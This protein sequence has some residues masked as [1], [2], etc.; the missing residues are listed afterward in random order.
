MDPRNYSDD[1]PFYLEK[2]KIEKDFKTVENVKFLI[3]ESS[4]ELKRPLRKDEAQYLVTY[5]RRFDFSQSGFKDLDVLNANI[6]RY[7][8]KVLSPDPSSIEQCYDAPYNASRE[9]LIRQ[10]VSGQYSYKEGGNISGMDVSSGGGSSGITPSYVSIPTSTEVKLTPADI[11]ALSTARGGSTTTIIPTEFY[12]N[13]YLDFDSRYRVPLMDLSQNF[14]FNVNTQGTL[15]GIVKSNAEIVNIRKIEVYPFEIPFTV[16][17]DNQFREIRMQMVEFPNNSVP[18]FTGAYYHFSFTSEPVG[19]RM[20]LT[21]KTKEFFFGSLVREFNYL[22]FNFFDPF[23]QIIFD[24]DSSTLATFT[25]AG[26]TTVVSN[27]F[28][29]A[30]ATGDIVYFINFHSVAGM[31]TAQEKILMDAQGHKITVINATDFSVN[32]N[33]STSLPP[34]AGYSMYFGS[35]RI[36]WRLRVEFIRQNVTTV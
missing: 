12:E 14:R 36:F 2:T 24:P 3:K 6:V 4:K 10:D 11:V 16:Q 13:V 15:L 21:P 5:I 7:M 26:P 28:S 32:V 34:L 29:H 35:K 23:N 27:S 31:T 9:E 17:T 20:K 1:D 19:G 30:L 33:M 22:T 25:S 8:K 18:T